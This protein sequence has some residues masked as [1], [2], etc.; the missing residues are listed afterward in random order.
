MHLPCNKNFFHGGYIVHCGMFLQLRGR[1]GNTTR[2]KQITK[3]TIRNFC[4]VL[5]E[6]TIN[7]AWTG[8]FIHRQREENSLQSMQTLGVTL[9]ILLGDTNAQLSQTRLHPRW[10]QTAALSEEPDVCN[11]SYSH[12]NVRFICKLNIEKVI[13]I[14]VCGRKKKIKAGR[15]KEER[16]ENV[17]TVSQRSRFPDDR[18]AANVFSLL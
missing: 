12:M 11:A 14:K 16:R 15:V 5:P 8:A 2:L 13:Y 17:S 4:A 1:F 10:K 9:S 6:K 3:T 7:P 18:C